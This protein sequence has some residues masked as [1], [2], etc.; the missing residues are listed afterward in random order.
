MKTRRARRNTFGQITGTA[1]DAI[2][3]QSILMAS[4]GN[5][6]LKFIS[7]PSRQPVNLRYVRN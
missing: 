4:F 2:I 3:G 1:D 6:T 5:F 7:T